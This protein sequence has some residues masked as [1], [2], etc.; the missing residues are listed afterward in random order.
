MAAC[1]QKSSCPLV[2]KGISNHRVWIRVRV[3]VRVRVGLGVRL[4]VGVRVKI[5]I[6]IP[7]KKIRGRKT[8][9]SRDTY[10]LGRTAY[11]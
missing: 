4:R 6:K 10:S 2:I 7:K 11:D 3:R 8:R 9:A 5:T 1:T